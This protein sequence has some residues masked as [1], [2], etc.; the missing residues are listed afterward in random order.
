MEYD[1]LTSMKNITKLQ[2]MNLI[3]LVKILYTSKYFLNIYVMLAKIT[4]A[5]PHNA[6]VQ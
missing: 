1:E 4:A 3:E 2:K 6:F 5:K